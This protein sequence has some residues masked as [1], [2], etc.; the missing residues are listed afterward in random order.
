[1]PRGWLL[2]LCLVLFVWPPLSFAGEV[3]STLTTL[4][5][6]GAPA[7]IELLAHGLVAAVSVAGAW[8][9]WSASPGG[10][11]LA[12]FALIGMGLTQVQSLYWSVLPRNTYPGDKLPRAIVVVLHSVVWLAY[13]RRSRMVKEAA[14][15]SR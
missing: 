3:A 14:Q 2:L 6:R 5:M 11:V 10:R 15:P 13:L 9:L 4:E 1:M 7:V 8:A 12:G